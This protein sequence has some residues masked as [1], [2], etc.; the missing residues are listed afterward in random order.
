M[1][2]EVFYRVV[3]TMPNIAYRL[4]LFFLTDARSKIR[5]KPTF[6]IERKTW[7]ISKANILRIW[8]RVA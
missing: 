5:V 6:L 1:G 8:T 3:N 7:P 2:E 4:D